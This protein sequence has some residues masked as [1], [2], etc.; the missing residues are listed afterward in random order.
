MFAGCLTEFREN[1]GKRMRNPSNSGWKSGSSLKCLKWRL[2]GMINPWDSGLIYFQTKSH[3]WQSAVP[4]DHCSAAVDCSY[5]PC[6]SVGLQHPFRDD[7]CWKSM[8]TRRGRPYLVWSWTL[9]HEVPRGWRGAC[10][11]GL[12][13]QCWFLL[14]KGPRKTSGRYK[15]PRRYISIQ[16]PR[17]ANFAKLWCALFNSRLFA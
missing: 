14:Q 5:K 8:A 10:H 12:W 11:L 13:R 16:I 3:H 9:R 4:V 7:S 15:K 1:D 6:L 17:Y 2:N